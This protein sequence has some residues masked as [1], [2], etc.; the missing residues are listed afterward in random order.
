[1][2]RDGSARVSKGFSGN[3][4]VEVLSKREKVRSSDNV[5]GNHHRLQDSSP[6]SAGGNRHSSMENVGT[7]KKG[8]ASGRRPP[9]PPVKR[10]NNKLAR[11]KSVKDEIT[12]RRKSK[13]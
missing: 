13:P 11:K 6:M 9:P 4:E 7:T 1:M 10:N 12:V 5:M 3:F 2:G 8:K